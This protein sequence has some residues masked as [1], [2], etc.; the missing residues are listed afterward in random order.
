M[1]DKQVR[2]QLEHILKLR[3][4]YRAAKQEATRINKLAGA[5]LKKLE[6]LLR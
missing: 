4:Q 6:K 1:N 5:E 2:K 3:A